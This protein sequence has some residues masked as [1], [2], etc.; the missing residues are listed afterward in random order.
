MAG[1]PA[2]VITTA[3][4]VKKAEAGPVTFANPNVTATVT[5]IE[6]SSSTSNTDKLATTVTVS[7]T[8]TFTNK[9]LDADGQIIESDLNDPSTF[10]T[11]KVGFD[12][13]GISFVGFIHSSESGN[14]TILSQPLN[15][16][17]V[18]VNQVFDL[19]YGATL[20]ITDVSGK[21]IS[22]N[23][24]APFSDETAVKIASDTTT[25]LQVMT[26]T[27]QVSPLAHQFIMQNG[28]LTEVSKIKNFNDQLA[29]ASQS[30]PNM[31]NAADMSGNQ[32]MSAGGAGGNIAKNVS[33]N[34]PLVASVLGDKLTATLTATPTDYSVATV[35]V[36]SVSSA[37]SAAEAAGSLSFVNP[38]SNTTSVFSAHFA[39]SDGTMLVGSLSDQSTW[40]PN[41][42]D[43]EIP[44]PETGVLVLNHISTSGVVTLLGTITNPA[45]GMY[46][47][48]SGTSLNITSISST[49]IYA[50]YRGPFG[51][52]AVTPG[53]ASIPCLV[54][55][56]RVAT[57]SGYVP[58]EQLK[59]GDMVAT[60][61]GKVVPIKMFQRTIPVTTAATAPYVIQKGA[62]GAANPAA[63][64]TLS[65]LHAIQLRKGVWEIP[66]YAASRYAGVQQKAV[67]EP[68]TYYHVETPDYFRDNLL[69]EGGVIVESF[70]GSRICS[71][72]P[73]GAKLYRYSTALAGFTRFSPT[74]TKSLK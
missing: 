73:A 11:M 27:A 49:T 20:T 8:V 26:T 12:I 66:K 63:D 3:A 16:Q 38:G 72:M 32:S 5:A 56:T 74:A 36:K 37:L 15:F 53:A 43:I 4:G 23:L 69:I 34:K 54:A 9:K 62:F 65:P 42:V 45:V 58:V 14:I 6:T 61:A 13:T 7:D 40:A 50:T 41:G 55:G 2:A 25:G 19:S 51:S 22:G 68:V 1:T 48:D 57:P 28:K 70:A 18:Q 17:G 35:T 29:G 71:Q 47:L 30:G 21:Y 60:A 24:F 33:M 10:D 46:L 44:I 59:S 52:F 64:V 67:G 31:V 39:K